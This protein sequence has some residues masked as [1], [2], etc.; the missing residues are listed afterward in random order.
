MTKK[1]KSQPIKDVTSSH[2]SP[3]QRAELFQMFSLM[4]QQSARLAPANDM[5]IAPIL[6]SPER[7]RM[8]P[9]PHG[10]KVTP[11]DAS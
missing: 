1:K 3:E 10:I 6:D 9:H 11:E 4:L 7:P 5:D 2:F 8:K